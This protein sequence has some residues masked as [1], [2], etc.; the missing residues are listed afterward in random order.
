MP[1]SD[2]KNHRNSIRY[3]FKASKTRLQKLQI[4]KFYRTPSHE[5]VLYLDVLLSLRLSSL[6]IHFSLMTKDS[7]VGKASVVFCTVFLFLLQQF[8]CGDMFSPTPNDLL[9]WGCQVE[10][11][12]RT[13]FMDLKISY[14][15]C[16]TSFYDILSKV[17]SHRQL[18]G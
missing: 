11:W 1:Y 15:F 3:C 8:C 7:D 10:R 2:K 4:S 6:S 13:G 9:N 12:I 14:I 16:L 17:V 5:L 18:M